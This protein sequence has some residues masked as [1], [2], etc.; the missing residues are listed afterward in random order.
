MKATNSKQT[1][2][3]S[4]ESTE[5][6][7]ASFVAHITPQQTNAF[8]QEIEAQHGAQVHAVSNDGKVVFTIEAQHQKHIAFVVEQFRNFIGLYSLSPVYHQFLT[9]E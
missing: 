4:T 1:N 9:E 7:V 6:H 5:Y 3:G 8:S 2:D